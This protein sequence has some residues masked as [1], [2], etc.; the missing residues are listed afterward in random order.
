[1]SVD[2]LASFQNAQVRDL[3]WVMAAPNLLAEAHWLIADSEC[4][5]WLEHAMPQLLALE[6]NPTP[7]QLWIAQHAPQRLGPYFEILLSYWIAHL[8]PA[9]WFSTN[10]I[11]KSGRIVLGEY[12]LLW[13]DTVGALQHWEASIKLYLQV[14]SAAGFAGYVGT[15]T[16]DRLDIKV[17]RL[18]DKQLQL[19]RT[20]E[21][22]AS[23]PLPDE[24][25]R[26]RALLKGW[27][28]YPVDTVPQPAE[29]VSV[30][31]LQGWWCR[32]GALVLPQPQTMRWKILPRL[33][34]LTPANTIDATTLWN[35]IDFMLH[36]TEHFSQHQAPVLVAGLV[37]V[38]VVWQEYTRGFVVPLDWLQDINSFNSV[39]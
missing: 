11:V 29:G 2:P 23:L 4:L 32:W 16:R 15:M 12:D 19:A 18:R 9:T 38:G 10:Q 27:L 7:L 21:G 14:D 17:T 8:M 13:R 1:M 5:S 31:H 33:A 30:R 36:L 25:V 39:V 20:P 22:A 28:F 35:N 6:Q 34:W 3:V 26:A 37:Q 24:A